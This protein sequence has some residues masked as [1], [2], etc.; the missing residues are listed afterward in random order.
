M[1]HAQDPA[2]GRRGPGGAPGGGGRPPG[3]PPPPRLWR[4]RR[5]RPPRA[6]ARGI[7]A[8]AAD[9]HRGE[10]TLEREAG[11]V[12]PR[13]GAGH[14]AILERPAILAGDRQ[15]YEPEVRREAGAPDDVRDVEGLPVIELR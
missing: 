9:Q 11:K 3:P 10:R 2:R 12:E 7:G 8:G 4:P 14:A 13:R 5:R 15:P 6:P 1:S